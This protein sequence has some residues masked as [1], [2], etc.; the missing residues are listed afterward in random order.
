MA[1]EGKN[2]GSRG[3]THSYSNLYLPLVS[4]GLGRSSSRLTWEELYYSNPPLVFRAL[5][6]ESMLARPSR[7]KDTGDFYYDGSGNMIVM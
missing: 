2:G 5:G 3:K 7:V 1:T 4:D 6:L